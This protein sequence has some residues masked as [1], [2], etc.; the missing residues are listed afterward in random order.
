L[1]LSSSDSL[2][3]QVILIR[4]LGTILELSGSYYGSIMDLS[5]NYHGT[6]DGIRYHRGGGIGPFGRGKRREGWFGAL[7]G[8][9]VGERCVV[10]RRRSEEH[11]ICDSWNGRGISAVNT[12]MTSC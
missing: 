2:G 6:L 8:I 10:W 11:E 4:N 9:V 1:G 12:L 5:W 7:R 3:G